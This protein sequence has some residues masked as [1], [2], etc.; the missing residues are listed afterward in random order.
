MRRTIILEM[1]PAGNPWVPANLMGMGLSK[2]SNP[3]LV[4][5]FLMGIDIFH[6]YGF[7]MAKS[8]GFV[9]VAI[10]TR[11]WYFFTQVS[12]SFFY[13]LFTQRPCWSHVSRTREPLAILSLSFVSFVNMSTNP[14]IIDTDGPISHRHMIT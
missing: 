7:E 8:S 10:S 2:I 9:P 6:G 4:Q 5:V 12:L 3:S 13:F 11:V 1:K 14:Q